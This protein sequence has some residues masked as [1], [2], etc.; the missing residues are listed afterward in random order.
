MKMK[1]IQTGIL[2]LIFM[3]LACTCGTSDST[4]I[5]QLSTNVSPQD[6]GTV[7]PSA[8]EFDEG[9]LVELEAEPSEEYLFTGWEGDITGSNNPY[10]FEMNSDIA[11]TAIFERK[12]YSLTVE[13]IGDG[14][15]EEEIVEAATK[16]DYGHGT[17]VELTAQPD[18]KRAFAHWEEDLEGEENPATL[19]IE[20]EKQV[21]AVFEWVAP[22]FS[23][24]C[25]SHNPGDLEIE[26][27]GEDWRIIDENE[28]ILLVFE[29]LENA[30]KAVD[31]IQFYGF[32]QQCYVTRPNAPLKY[33]LISGAPP[34]TSEEVPFGED[35]LSHNLG[36]LEIEEFG[37][38]WR[39]VDGESALLLF[40]EFDVAQKAL[41][42]IQF[43]EF[44]QRCY[45]GRPD[46]GMMYWLR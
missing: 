9:S 18:D 43:Y 32:T 3:N 13:V 26:E 39:I 28:N 24:D 36:D 8:G 19:T 10:S 6:A 23:D 40:E 20:D 33:W 5:Y 7:S 27:F 44:K 4:E 31:I 41:D 22:P 45:V 1:R 17:V 42:V 21:T 25:L 37:D 38:N 30:Q 12:Q 2:L 34:Q 14:S 16:T 15:V 46:P 29:E 11:V 35:C